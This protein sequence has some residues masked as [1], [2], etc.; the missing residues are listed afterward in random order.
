MIIQRP[1]YLEKLIRY[2]DKDIVKSLQVGCFWERP[3]AQMEIFSWETAPFTY[4]ETL[5]TTIS[6]ILIILPSSGK[7]VILSTSGFAAMAS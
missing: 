1:K 2:K 4:G 6:S 3:T 7:T 5:M